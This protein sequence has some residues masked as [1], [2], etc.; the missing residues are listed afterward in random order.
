MAAPISHA[1]VLPDFNFTD[2]Y[3]AAESYT[4]TFDRVVVVRSP[5]GN[6]LNRFRNVTAIQVPNVWYKDDAVLH[7]RQIYP[8]VVRVDVIK[9]DTPMELA[10]TLNERIS[11]KDRFGE[12][13]NGDKH[14]ND[15][16]V[17]GW[18]SA[19]VPAR[20]VQPFNADLGNKLKNEGV[21]IPAPKGTKITAVG[22]GTVAVVMKTSTSTGYG[23]YVQ[24]VQTFQGQNYIITY[25]NLQNIV[26]KMGQLV[27]QDD[28]LGECAGPTTKL[29]IQA[30]G[31]GKKGYILTDIVDPTPLIYW[32]GLRLQTTVD[33]LRIRAQAGAQFSPIGQ[34]YLYDELETL[35]PHGRTLAKIGITDAWIR[36]RT[37]NGLEGYGA[38]WYLS[39][40]G[41][42]AVDSL[43]MTG[44][45][46][47]LSFT[48]G[49]PAPERL[50]GLGWVRF[51]YNVSQG[52][53]STDFNAADAIYRPYIQRYAAA[54][55]R[56]IVILGHQTYGEGHYNW[57]QMSGASWKQ[58]E[59]DFA[60]ACRE[61]ARRYASGNLV[62]AYQIWNEQDT[63]PQYAQAA[64]AVPADEYG[65]LMAAAIK[66]IR[67][68]D[69][70]V[71]IIT[72]GHVTGLANGPAYARTALN[73]MPSGV[74]PDGIAFHAYGLGAP[75]SNARYTSFG[76]LSPT[77]LAYSKVM[78]A[79]VWITEFGTLDVPN[80]PAA[81][82]SKYATAFVRNLK[83][84]Y[85]DKVAAA[86]WY[87]WADGMHNGYGLVDRADK[88]KQP[89]YD[90]FHKV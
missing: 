52:K 21:T 49:R 74:R 43:N 71:K 36:L 1:L 24:V 63:P 67:S 69:A 61:V 42:D 86:V 41:V 5:A 33:G 35:E 13:M 70:N 40:S 7:I 62:G 44:V 15:R 50:K 32:D 57:N 54:G 8:M 83:S 51:V 29:V 28:P 64:V 2:W 11:K 31:K 22:A 10:D 16:F 27:K 34:V 18:P 78:S 37:P 80:D 46:L 45:N 87:G 68:V 76:A 47:D 81:D 90:D 79:P 53:G 72:G 73:A 85:P 59:I 84:Y 9:A 12:T 4:N 77:V 26:V 60:N 82:I 39:A 38:A 89:F 65:R 58:L 3:R 55:L 20:I 48:L 17:V 56:P 14:L 75:G 88:P 6:D 30:P 19:A 66:A 25:T 23:Q